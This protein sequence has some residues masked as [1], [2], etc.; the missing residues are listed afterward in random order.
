ML[1]Q[2]MHALFGLELES[3]IEDGPDLLPAFR[4]LTR[5]IEV[6]EAHLMALTIIVWYRL[7]RHTFGRC[8]RAV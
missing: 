4:S 8:P 2:Q 5:S 3:R 6:L 7:S 1:P